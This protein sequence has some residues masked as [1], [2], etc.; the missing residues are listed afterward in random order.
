MSTPELPLDLN[1]Q[2]ADLAEAIEMLRRASALLEVERMR[3]AACGVAAMQ[4]TPATIAQRV[5]RNS[6]YY[7]ASYEDVCRAVDREISLRAQMQNFVDICRRF[8]ERVERG[9]GPKHQDVWRS[10][11]GSAGARCVERATLAAMI[12]GPAEA[13]KVTQADDS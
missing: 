12:R 4:N 9:G 8:T 10:E 13:P 3:L 2:P 5:D 7:S 11:G 6:P 1:H